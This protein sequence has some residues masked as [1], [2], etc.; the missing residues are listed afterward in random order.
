MLWATV[1]AIV[2]FV[3][4]I[5]VTRIGA[6]SSLESA[7]LNQKQPVATGLF[8]FIQNIHQRRPSSARVLVVS[9]KVDSSI[10]FLG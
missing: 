7:D 5:E 9:Q 10:N 3:S 1:F 6:R 8:Q 4:P 2:R